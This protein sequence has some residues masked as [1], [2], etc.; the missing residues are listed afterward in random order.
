[1][2]QPRLTQISK[3]LSYILRHRPQT[4]GLILETDGW[5]NVNDILNNS[6]LPL[7]LEELQAV[8]AQNDKQR[9]SFNADFTKIKANQ[10]HSVDVALTFKVVTPP[11]TLYHGTAQ[12]YLAS[13]LAQGLNKGSRHHVHLSKDILTATKVGQ[14]HGEPVVLLVAAQK[15]YEEGY[16]FY[17]SDNEVYLVEQVPANY[18]KT[19]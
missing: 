2:N 6:K 17:L 10:G 11:A 15:M 4:I 9:F 18:L 3:F 14:R 1:M 16:T 7:C 8:V 12:R 5:A 19:V 13:I